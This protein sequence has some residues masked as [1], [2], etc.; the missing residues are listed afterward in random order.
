VIGKSGALRRYHSWLSMGQRLADALAVFALLPAL[1][2]VRGLPYG[3][4]YQVTA[5]LGA[6]LTW[7]AMGAVDAYRPWRGA[8][9]LREIRVIAAAWMLVL[10]AMLLI[11][12]GVKFTGAYSRLVVGGWFVVSPLALVLLHIA[13]RSF[14]RALRKRGR[15][16]RTAVIVGA[17]DLG[18]KFRRPDLIKALTTVH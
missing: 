16:R 18:G 1:C 9:L 17:G 8:S 12:W 4:P 15:N 11:A 10:G 7:A 2:M 13:E 14:L 3:Q 5:V 6:L